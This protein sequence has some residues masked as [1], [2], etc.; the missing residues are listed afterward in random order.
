MTKCI[1]FYMKCITEF[2]VLIPL[3]FHIKIKE[4]Y[5]FFYN[6]FTISL[7][8]INLTLVSYFDIISIEEV[9]E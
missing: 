9:G 3:Y 5:S 8:Y 6:N 2:F 4:I 1:F 7:L